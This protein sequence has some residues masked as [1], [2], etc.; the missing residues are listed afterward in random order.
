MPAPLPNPLALT[1]EAFALAST[2][3]HLRGGRLAA[4]ARYSAAFR[5]GIVSDTLAPVDIAPIARIQRSDSP[6][7][8]VIKFTQRV[9]RTSAAPHSDVA[10]S[11]PAPASLS[12]PITDAP[13]L[14]TAL[15]R[16]IEIASD[17]LEIESVLIPMIGRTQT[18]GYTLCL[19]SQV[20]CAMGCTFCQT[21]QMGL[22]RSLTAAEIVGQWF[23]A[24]HLVD[25]TTAPGPISNIVFMGMGE[26]MDNLDSVIAAI[27]ILTDR[28]GP[29]LAMS[30]I[31]VST[32]GRL[33]GIARLGARVRT[34]GWHRLGLA[35][36]LNA[37]SDA[38]RSAIM[39]INRAMPLRPLRA[40]LLDWPYF[41]GAHLCLEYV[42]IPGV[43]DS[44]RH[45]LELG[46]FYHG[47]ASPINERFAPDA[48]SPALLANYAA[49]PDSARF[50]GPRLRALVNLIPYNPRENSPW[51]APD[52]SRV[53]EFL[54]ALISL[55][56]IAKRRRTKGRAQMAA[57]GQLGNLQFKKPKRAASV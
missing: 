36:S 16:S 41:A 7:G 27:E 8:E 53:E 12:L 45:A 37:P 49:L 40:A 31:T 4:L 30:R 20:G 6:E 22:I 11:M 10:P 35:I 1:S 47:E 2:A 15:T 51:P 43:N 28:R 56:V 13:P 33:D 52:E 19:S 55:G 18:R 5:N 9:P 38:A 50:P 32:V 48:H 39:P 24:Q 25:R 46:A 42:L 3:L 29:S 21:A 26:P 44:P 54:A 34:T 17:F 57:C 14:S 23:A